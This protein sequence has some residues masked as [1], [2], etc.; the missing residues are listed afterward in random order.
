MTTDATT[1]PGSPARAGPPRRRPPRRAAEVVTSPAGATAS[2]L[3]PGPSGGSQV[4]L[5][6]QSNVPGLESW[7]NLVLAFRKPKRAP[8]ATLSRRRAEWG[9]ASPRRV[10]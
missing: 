1:A 6:R 2:G 3:V 10:G 5:V 8:A 7:D 9:G 4:A